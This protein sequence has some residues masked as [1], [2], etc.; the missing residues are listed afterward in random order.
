M[1]KVVIHYDRAGRSLGTADVIFA[2]REDA[3]TAA[4][5]Y[6]NAKIEGTCIIIIHS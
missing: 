2:A 6:N 1:K 4:R 5:K 3:E